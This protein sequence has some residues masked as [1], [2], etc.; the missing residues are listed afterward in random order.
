MSRKEVTQKANQSLV[1]LHSDELPES[2][3]ASEAI[4]GSGG[5]VMHRY[6]SR[7][8]IGRISEKVGQG[9]AARRDVRSLHHA[10]V[11]REPE[12]LSEAEQLGLEAWNLRQSKDFEE[13]K[14][15]RPRDGARW[16]A[17]DMVEPPDGRGMIHVGESDVLGAPSLAIED[18][19]PY[20]IGSVAV[21][22]I[23]VE[24]PTAALRFTD[25]Q[26]VKIVA[27]VQEGLTWL[28]KQEPRAS[29]TW[30]YDIHTVRVDAEPDASLTGYEPLEGLWRNPAMEKLGFK[31]NYKGVRD[32]V[33]SIRKGLGTRWGYV[34]YFTKYPIQHFAYASKPSLV[35]HYD[36][37]GWG[38]DNIDRLFTHET[39]HIFGCPDEYEDSDCNCTSRYGYLRVRNGNCQTCASPFVD[40]LMAANTWAMCQYTPA[41]LGWRDKD[42]DGT[43]D[44]VDPLASPSL[45]VDLRRVRRRFPSLFESLG[46]EGVV[47]ALSQAEGSAHESIPLFL[48]RRILNAGEMKRVEEALMAEE[49]Q[50]V[51]ALA[52]KL[53]AITK[54]LKAGG[55]APAPKAAATAAKKVRRPTKAA[56]KSRP[57]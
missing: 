43:L 4:E 7:V 24:G 22:I 53:Q 33:A 41:H 10:A 39:G 35:M 42:G 44:P 50:F 29:V 57:R 30:S 27:E 14:V 8:L 5:Q 45:A 9:L 17:R 56:R 31:A 3:R 52:R 26:K 19:S 18:T 36:N 34:A 12:K 55:K 38:P 37:D 21:G 11:V 48:L 28:G 16:D 6:G 15:E 1:V 32:Y 25:K 47:P 46:L 40:C 20:L 13:A 2:H 49:D 54:D 51:E 23:M